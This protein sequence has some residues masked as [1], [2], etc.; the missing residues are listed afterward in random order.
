VRHLDCRDAPPSPPCD[1]GRQRGRRHHRH[2]FSIPV[3]D[4]AP[5]TTY[6]YRAVGSN[7]AGENRSLDATFTTPAG[8]TTPGTSCT[9]G[10]GAGPP[11]NGGGGGGDV[12]GACTAGC[13]TSHTLD[14]PALGFLT[15]GT[16]SRAQRTLG[17]LLGLTLQGPAA[18]LAAHVALRQGL[19]RHAQRPGPGPGT[20]RTT[21]RYR[22]AL[23]LTTAGRLDVELTRKG[24]VG[25]GARYRFRRSPG[26]VVSR[27]VAHRCLSASAAKHIKRP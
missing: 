12:D 1:H 18:Q 7:L 22:R 24:W 19:P 14:E 2:A 13:A 21:R 17:S 8:P 4:L 9:S 26:A 6:H 27:R 10:C 5:S 20:A 23:V 15:R 25:R 16:R 3:E 11:P